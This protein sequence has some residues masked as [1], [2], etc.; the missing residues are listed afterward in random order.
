MQYRYILHV[1][2][3][4]TDVRVLLD[5]LD[6]EPLELAVQLGKEELRRQLE[7]SV[8]S[9]DTQS[10]KRWDKLDADLEILSTYLAAPVVAI[11]L[12]I[13]G[14]AAHGHRILARQ[15]EVVRVALELAQTEDGSVDIV[16]E[17]IDKLTAQ[18]SGLPRW[19]QSL[20]APR[21]PRVA[22]VHG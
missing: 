12:V 8:L 4:A 7:S 19:A 16:G 3:P 2:I 14:A 5:A 10:E 13:D 22:P 20:L 11:E 21:I 9:V 6:D 15:G 18:L 1:D 17:D